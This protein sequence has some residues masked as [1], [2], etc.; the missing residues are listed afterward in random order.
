MHEAKTRCSG[1]SEKTLKTSGREFLHAEEVIL[2]LDE[3]RRREIGHR[4]VEFDNAFDRFVDA[5]VKQAKVEA[6]KYTSEDEDE[7]QHNLAI[8]ALDQALGLGDRLMDA[9]HEKVVTSPDVDHTWNSLLAD[10][11]RDQ[12]RR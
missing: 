5:I 3:M 12:S 2:R 4:A 1:R 8:A 9:V 11:R 10:I 6:S 7:A